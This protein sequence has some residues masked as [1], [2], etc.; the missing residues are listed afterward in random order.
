MGVMMD[1]FSW[2]ADQFWSATPHETWALI[3]ARQEA[4]KRIAGGA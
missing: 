3:D 2:T 4:N 1:G